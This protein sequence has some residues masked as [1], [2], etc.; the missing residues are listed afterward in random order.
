LENNVMNKLLNT[1]FAALAVLSL[2]TI[3]ARAEH[4]GKIQVLLLGDSTTEGSIPRIMKPKGPHL[5]KVIEQLLAAEGDLPSTHVIQSGVSGEYIRRLIDSGRYDKAAAKLPGL[6]YIFV[7]YGINDRARVEDFENEFP[8]H[9]HEL[10]GLLRRD[11]PQAIIVPT[12]NI[13]FSGP[14]ETAMMND[15]VRQV[16]AKENLAV[17]DLNPRYAAELKKG[18]NVL[19]YRRY[20]LAKVPEKFHELVKPYVHGASVLVMS[21][22]LDGILGHLPGWFSDRHPNLAGYNVIADE[23]AKY[24]APLIREKFPR[25]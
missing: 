21:N 2:L 13:P 22:E 18:M 16:A 14:E 7:R 24:L 9:L 23:T 3:P 15:L 11:H 10:I 25:K 6:D 12:T 20:P 5:E 4:E 17:F 19:N 1:A 8:K